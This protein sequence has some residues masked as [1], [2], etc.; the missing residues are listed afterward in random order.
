MALAVLRLTEKRLLKNS[1]CEELYKEQMQDMVTCGVAR[2]LTEDEIN[3]YMGPVQYINHQEVIRPDSSSTPCRI[4]FNSSAN[5]RGHI[6]NDCWA[7]GPDMLINLLGLMLRFRERTHPFVGDIKKMYHS[8]KLSNLDQHTH[9]FLW[10]DWNSSIEPKTFVM[11]S[12]SF[13]D[14]PAAAISA[15]AL[16]K[17]A[18]MNAERYPLASNIILTNTY[19]DDIID[20]LDSKEQSRKVS[21]EIDKILETGNME[22]KEWYILSDDK[23]IDINCTFNSSQ[24]VLGMFWDTRIDVFRFRT[25][26]QFTVKRSHLRGQIESSTVETENV[27]PLQLTKRCILSKINSLYDLMGLLSPFIVRAKILMKRLWIGDCK[28]LGWD[29][30]TPRERREGWHKFF[31]DVPK[32][33]TSCFP[34]CLKSSECEGHPILVIFCDGS[35]EVYGACS[36]I[37]WKTKCNRILTRLIAAKCRVA[38]LKYTSI[39]RIE[40]AGALLASR[41]LSFIKDECRL[42]F[43]QTY[44]FTNSFFD[45]T[46][47]F[48]WICNFYCC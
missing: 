5:Y 10:R 48:V 13:G 14:R 2:Q 45:D 43:A 35:E 29:D 22:I 41:L 30:P 1:E 4:V 21:E 15:V 8:I 12:V 23:E 44:L 46:T 11:T 9:R 31:S 24:K 32:L 3:S 39:P 38:P 34:R 47:R 20:S 28:G 17:T 36:Y 26:L 6:M 7:K 27:V 40:L 19:V 25:N 33:E 37:H 18:E 42:K 16:K